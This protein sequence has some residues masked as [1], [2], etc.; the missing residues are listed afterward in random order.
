M[1]KWMLAFD[2]GGGVVIGAAILLLM[3]LT[4][5]DLDGAWR[6]RDWEAALLP[7]V[8]LSLGGLV[9]GALIVV[10]LKR[11]LITGVAGLLMVAVHLMA[12]YQLV[13]LSDWL[14]ERL[15][16]FVVR[17]LISFPVVLGTILIGS[18]LW[19]ARSLRTS[20]RADTAKGT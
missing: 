13:T 14:G 17:S 5:P 15:M 3:G 19:S 8:L 7:L 12:M 11:P 16:R 9:I 6:F 1:R 18:A 4:W 2:V 10:L 20:K